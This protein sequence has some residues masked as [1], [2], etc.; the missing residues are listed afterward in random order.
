MHS[1]YFDESLVSSYSIV[2]LSENAGLQLTKTEIL[3]KSKAVSDQF[4][5]FSSTSNFIRFTYPLLPFTYRHLNRD[6]L[7]FVREWKY[8]N[9]KRG[10]GNK[11]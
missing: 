3:F 1:R 7:K 10:Y 8:V 2:C 5:E 4:V 11:M 9:H 6:D